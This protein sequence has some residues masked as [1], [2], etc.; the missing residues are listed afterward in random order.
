M[1]R[2]NRI[3]PN[4][5]FGTVLATVALLASACAAD[6]P[7][8]DDPADPDPAVT[9]PAAAAEPYLAAALPGPPRTEVTGTV[10]QGQVVAVG[11]LDATG[12]ALDRVDLYD[13]E[14]DTWSSGPEL[15]V[16][17]HHTAV[18]TLGD[19]LYVVGGYAIAGGAWVAQSEVYS[20]GPDESAW[21]QEPSLQTS[22]GALAVASTGGRLVAIGGVDPTRQVLAST[23][24][25]DAGSESWQAGPDMAT[26]REHLDA[27]AVGEDVY[28]I[29]GRAGGF[30]TNRTS[31]EVLRNG[32]WEEAPPVQHA[33][34]GIGAAT[35][36]QTPCVTGGEEPGSTI[37]TVECLLEDEW[38]VVAQLDHPRHGL[39]VAA[40]NGALHVIGGGTEPG[41][42]VSDIHEVIPLNLP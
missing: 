15:P 19:R 12:A 27:A 2:L 4:H 31:V 7:E 30:E 41:L 39:V 5:L 11:G 6:T 18:E 24:F 42:T 21:Q 3:R 32:T 36:G 33:R 1:R 16:P 8:S 9:P 28:A 20:L 13:P 38:V 10:W 35:V 14:T 29:S 22:R 34:G 40:V 25:L 26:P 37:G 17:L 23:E